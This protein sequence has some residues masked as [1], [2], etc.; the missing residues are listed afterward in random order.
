MDIAAFI[1]LPFLAF[2][3]AWT[4]RKFRRD[5]VAWLVFVPPFVSFTVGWGWMAVA[6]NTKLSLAAAQMAFDTTYVLSYFISF[7]IL[8]EGRPQSR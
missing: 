7:L 3:G 4:S 1:S 6:R 8:G 2:L 5:G